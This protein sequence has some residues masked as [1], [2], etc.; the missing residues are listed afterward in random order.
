MILD[1]SAVVAVFCQEPAFEGLLD[2]L[3][4]AEGLGMGTP[5]IVET[6]IVLT[7]RLR[8]DATG[9]LE[10]FL[11]EF[12]V[13]PVPFAA[14]HWREAHDAYVRFGKGRH[15]AQLSFGDCMSYATAKLARRPLL[16][17][18]NDFRRTDIDIA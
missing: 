11:Q 17:V 18:G 4:A 9:L 8:Q 5:T 15:R 6:A 3:A 13:E 16:C 2:K 12:A 10:R 7:A 1:T 14:P